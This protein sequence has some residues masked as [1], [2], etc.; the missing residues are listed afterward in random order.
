MSRALIPVALAALLVPLS[1]CAEKQASLTPEPASQSTSATEQASESPSAGT[2]S[3]GEPSQQ[4]TAPA[5]L[6]SPVG[7]KEITANGVGYKLSLYPLQRSGKAVLLTADLEYAKLA[8]GKNPDTRI[9]SNS[10]SVF[11]A[12]QGV[13]NGFS[14]VD[15]AGEKM[16]LPALA[17]ESEDSALCSPSISSDGAQGDVVT[18]VCTFGGIP[19]ATTAM[20]VQTD[21]FGS[22]ANVP[23]K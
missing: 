3:A 10:K 8:A 2:P 14:L 9:L 5:E 12:I 20:T 4:S 6:G 11:S 23:I 15:Q 19:D 17:N 18:V 16:Y 7:S 22:Y 1:G 21:R 13:P